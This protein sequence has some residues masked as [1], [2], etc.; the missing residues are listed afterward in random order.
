MKYI[1]P[2][3]L[4]LLTGLSCNVN[5]GDYDNI[6]KITEY[7]DTNSFRTAQTCP[8]GEEDNLVDIRIVKGGNPLLETEFQ[9]MHDLNQCVLFYIANPE[10]GAF[11]EGWWF[12]SAAFKTLEAAVNEY[13]SGG[14]FV[15]EKAHVRIEVHQYEED[16]FISFA[17]GEKEI[18]EEIAD[19]NARLREESGNDEEL[20]RLREEIA[21]T[22][23]EI[24]ELKD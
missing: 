10:S 3:Y 2:T 12:R 20:A 11:S 18:L 16:G 5:A 4:L 23:R 22:L 8:E 6:I 19:L 13:V 1:L 24:A 14:E 7:D 17:I 21:A 9:R 15:R